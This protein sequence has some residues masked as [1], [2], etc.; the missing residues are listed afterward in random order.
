MKKDLTGKKFG[1]L[2][3]IGIDEEKTNESKKRKEKGEIKRHLIYWKCK[4]ECGNMVSRT[5]Q[6]IES[7]KN[8]SCGCLTKKYDWSN[9]IGMKFGKWT[10]IDYSKE[11]NDKYICRCECG[12][13]SDIGRYNLVTGKSKDCGCGRKSW[14]RDYNSIDITGLKCN[15]LT[16]I[17]KA[18]YKDNKCY[19]KCECECGN[20]TYRSTGKLTSGSAYSC[21]CGISKYGQIMQ[22]VVSKLGYSSKREYQINNP[23][24]DMSF[25]R[26]DLY[27]P[28]L[29]LAIE[30]DGE[31]HY[32]VIDWGKQGKDIAEQEFEKARYHDEIKNNYCKEH[33]IN[34][35]RIP[36]WEKENI[37][38]IIKNKINE[39]A[40]VND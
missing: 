24:P 39:L 26:F 8:P 4:C 34:L 35:L 5:A 3:V 33:N 19:W 12:T 11:S 31:C 30:Y 17:E 38:L 1:A 15:K 23:H 2:T 37:E 14:L 10:I 13:I 32:H 27:I 16:V 20:V 40:T 36:Y 22:D 25:F 21:G 18:Y 28:E 29:N 6:K 9:A 7:S